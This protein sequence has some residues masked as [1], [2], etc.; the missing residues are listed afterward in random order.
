M[1]GAGHDYA[2]SW[3]RFGEPLLRTLMSS[4][5]LR[6]KPLRV[7]IFTHRTRGAKQHHAEFK[8]NDYQGL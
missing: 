1:R 4:P 3:A 2:E 8:R 5:K 6:P 7:I